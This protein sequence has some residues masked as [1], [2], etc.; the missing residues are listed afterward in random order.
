MVFVRGRC[1]GSSSQVTIPNGAWLL[2]TN[3]DAKGYP[4]PGDCA[5]QEGAEG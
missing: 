5:A 2:Q 1:D 4:R 3:A